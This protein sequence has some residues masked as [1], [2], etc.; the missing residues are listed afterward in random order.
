MDLGKLQNKHYIMMQRVANISAYFL[1]AL[2]TSLPM[3][4]PL[5]INALSLWQLHC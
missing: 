4:K 3:E 1:Y 2:A 5:Q